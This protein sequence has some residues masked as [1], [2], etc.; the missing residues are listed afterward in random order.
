MTG[1]CVLHSHRRRRAFP[2]G[3]FFRAGADGASLQTVFLALLEKSLAADAKGFSAAA[4]LVTRCF[5]GGGD[6]FAFNFLEGPEPGERA[7]SARRGGAQ[8]F[9]KM[10]RLEEVA[11][12]S[13]S[14]GRT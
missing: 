8:I 1:G 11:L 13:S 2:G 6:D 4:D 7:G 9:R 5:E 10:F 3:E 14:A 12:G